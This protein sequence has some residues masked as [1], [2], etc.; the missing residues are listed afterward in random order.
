MPTQ[1]S[2]RVDFFPNGGTITSIKGYTRDQIM[3]GDPSVPDDILFIDVNSGIAG[4]MTDKTGIISDFPVVEREGYTFDGWWYTEDSD[5]INNAY[6][7]EI[8]D[9]ANAQKVD[10]STSFTKWA[11]GDWNVSGVVIAKWNKRNNG[12][13]GDLTGDNKVT[14]ADVLRLA[15]GAAGYVTLTEQEQKAGDVTGDGKITMADV[16]RIA[17]YAAGYSS[18]L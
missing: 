18:T 5:V 13:S 2:V 17:R 14:M 6:D 9:F 12:S 11:Y 4:M 3:Q 10:H 8:T 16:I 15:R 1:K 7:R